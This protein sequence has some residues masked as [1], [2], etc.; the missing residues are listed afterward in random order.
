M[1]VDIKRSLYVVRRPR[2]QER[3]KKEVKGRPLNFRPFP[4]PGPTML[5]QIPKLVPF[6]RHTGHS[7]TGTPTNNHRRPQDP[8]STSTSSLISS[9]L[10]SSRDPAKK[11]RRKPPYSSHRPT[12]LTRHKRFPEKYFVCGR[13]SRP[14]PLED[15]L[16]SPFLL[17]KNRK[18]KADRTHPAPIYRPEVRSG[19]PGDERSICDVR[20]DLWGGSVC[21][22]VFARCVIPHGRFGERSI[23]AKVGIAGRGCGN[24]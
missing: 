8:T 11:K 13:P 1:G 2:A 23:K 3:N 5:I 20:E 21:E 17:I 16:F 6:P 14:V 15:R 7:N 9:H 12:R 10:I 19:E 4:L 22:D 24:V 18:K